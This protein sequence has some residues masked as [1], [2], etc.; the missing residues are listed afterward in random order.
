VQQVREELAHVAQL[1]R[2][3]AVNRLVLFTED[4]LKGCDVL[5]VDHTEALSEQTEELLVR[6]LLTATIE[7]H[8]AQ[9]H[10]AVWEE[11]E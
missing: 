10:L 3:Q 5:P 11:Y 2:L 9:L 1:V 8:V 6:A 4:R 7:H